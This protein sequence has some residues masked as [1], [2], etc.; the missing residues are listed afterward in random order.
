MRATWRL[1]NRVIEPISLFRLVLVRRNE[2]DEVVACQR[3]EI[4]LV[5]VEEASSDGRCVLDKEQR[6]D[7]KNAQRSLPDLAIALLT[8]HKPQ[9]G[10]IQA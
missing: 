10:Y 7:H 5:M 1:K 3:S 4:P 9:R 2:A 8:V 6:N